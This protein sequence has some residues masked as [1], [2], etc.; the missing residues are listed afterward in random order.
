LIEEAQM[1]FGIFAQEEFFE[2]YEFTC[3]Y[4][5]AGSGVE[6]LSVDD[7][8]A[9]AGVDGTPAVRLDYTPS[10]GNPELREL[11]AG[12]YDGAESAHVFVAVGA[13]EALLI[14]YNLVVEAGDE[15]V[16]LSPG[17]QP[18]FEYA[19]AAGGTVREVPV[20][21]DDRGAAVDVDAVIDAIGPR[22]RLVTLNLP[23]NPTGAVLSVDEVSA[24]AVVAAS[25]GA[26]LLV[27]EVFRE[28][29]P[30]VQPSAWRCAD[31]VWVVN[32]LSKA[33]GLPGLRIG[34][35]LA[36]PDNIIAARQYRKY[37]SLN[38]GALD[39]HLAARAL[40]H[41]DA[42][43]GRGHRLV[44]GGLER[45]EEWL[46]HHSQWFSWRRSPGGSIAFLRWQPGGDV[47]AL[48]ADL[49][50][51]TGV[52]LGPGDVCYGADGFVRLGFATS[53]L[54]RGLGEMSSYLDARRADYA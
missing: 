1:R 49:A 9:L 23:H 46:Q 20:S 26:R 54:E 39:Q 10:T 34:W 53:Q 27:D 7:L 32:S 42:L 13:I 24:I 37:T 18:L 21:V 6:P 12:R 41:G 28:L 22:T 48:C 5:L 47:A 14:A 38:P 29:R 43:L 30:P 2:R 35:L 52:L 33:Y 25:H 19:R 8:R 36:D 44:T 4:M 17:Y 51:T 16:V 40:E 11:I 31:N 3:R 15:V 45:L 50:D